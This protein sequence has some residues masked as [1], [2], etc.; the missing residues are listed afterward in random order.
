MSN[1]THDPDYPPDLPVTGECVAEHDVAMNKYYD[2]KRAE[3][4][5]VNALKKARDRA[6]AATIACGAGM[7]FGAGP[8]VAACVAGVAATID[9]LND[10]KAKNDSFGVTIQQYS[11]IKQKLVDCINAS[12]IVIELDP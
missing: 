8:G 9:A 6:G 5:A 10:A 7:A 1:G 11:E 3:S 2:L 4:D 12:G